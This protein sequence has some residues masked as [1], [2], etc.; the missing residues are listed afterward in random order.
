MNHAIPPR[1]HLPLHRQQE[2]AIDRL[3]DLLRAEDDPEQV[4]SIV[5]I[6]A[7]GS[8]VSFM[9]LPGDP[10]GKADFLGEQWLTALWMAGADSDTR[11]RAARMAVGHLRELLAF[12]EQWEDEATHGNDSSVP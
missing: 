10:M 1:N 4:L 12:I 2:K 6:I 11:A 9:A 8:G 3:L 7:E 5:S